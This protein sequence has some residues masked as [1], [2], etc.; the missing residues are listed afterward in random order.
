MILNLEILIVPSRKIIARVYLK[1]RSMKSRFLDLRLYGENVC[2][3]F[4]GE[5]LLTF[6]P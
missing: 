6:H 3:F 4:H 5:A 2:P 1:P